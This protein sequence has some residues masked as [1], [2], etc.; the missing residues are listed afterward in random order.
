M[1]PNSLA[2]VPWQALIG[3]QNMRGGRPQLSFTAE[4]TDTAL[5]N[6]GARVVQS[7][8]RQSLKAIMLVHNDP[9]K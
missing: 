2:Q 3:M 6:C 1:W 4:V 9:V 8:K 5:G 7:E